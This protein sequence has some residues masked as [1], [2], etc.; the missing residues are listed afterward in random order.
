[1]TYGN[2]E[3]GQAILPPGKTLMEI[4]AL[5]GLPLWLARTLSELEIFPTSF[6]KYGICYTEHILKGDGMHQETRLDTAEGPMRDRK[7]RDMKGK[8]L[9]GA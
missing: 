1:M 7:A 5:G 9:A 2:P 3:Q 4:K 6:S 8:V